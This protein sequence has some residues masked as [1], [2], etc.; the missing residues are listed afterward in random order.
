M[1]VEI[2]RPVA[3]R[4]EIRASGTFDVPE[5]TGRHW[6]ATG[7]AVVKSESAPADA[8]PKVHTEP[9]PAPEYAA[10]SGKKSRF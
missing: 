10:R 1:R 5:V 2:L 4:G 3:L 7:A 8:P 9:A 6:I